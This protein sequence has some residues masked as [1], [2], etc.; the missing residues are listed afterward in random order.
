MKLPPRLLQLV[1]ASNPQQNGT[2]FI[3][4]IKDCIPFRALQSGDWTLYQ[5]YLDATKQVSCHSVDTFKALTETL[6]TAKMPPIE[7][8]LYEHTDYYWVQD[9][10][11]RLCI[12]LQRGIT[13]IPLKY[14]SVTVFEKAQEQIREALR[15]TV[16]KTHYNGWNNRLEC[17]YHSFDLFSMHIQ[18]QRNPAKRLE[19]IRPAYDFTGKRILDLGCN[20][21]GMLLHIPE[22]AAGLGVDYDANCLRAAETIRDKFQFSSSLQFYQADLN[23]LSVPTLLSALDYDPD[24]TFLLSIGSWVQTWRT[25]YRDAWNCSKAILLETNNDKEGAPQ[26]EFFRELGGQIQCLSE[27]SDDDCTGNLGRKTYLIL[28]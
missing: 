6:D 17:G 12:L 2:Y 4:P 11:H 27:S 15:T 3:L 26:L 8:N 16:G 14:L 19:R 22:A 23:R 28:R 13:H 9:G 7:L 21:G 18:G 25:L 5:E 24:I 10:I 20:T 1:L